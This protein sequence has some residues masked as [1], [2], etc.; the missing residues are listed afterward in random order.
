MVAEGQPDQQP[1][2]REVRSSAALRPDQ[3]PVDDQGHEHQVERIDLGHGRRGPDRAHGAHR[4]GRRDRQDRADTQPQRDQAE[5]DQADGHV[6]RRQEVGPEGN[7][8]DRQQLGQPGHHDVGRVAGGV[9]NAQDVGHGGHLAPVTERHAGH[10]RPEVDQHRHDGD[11][12]R[13]VPARFADPLTDHGQRARPERLRGWYRLAHRAV[14]GRQSRAFGAGGRRP[15]IRRGQ[16]VG[17]VAAPPGEHA[18]RPGIAP[19]QA[20]LFRW[21]GTRRGGIASRATQRLDPGRRRPRKSS[22][23]QLGI[24]GDE[25]AVPLHVPDDPAAG[26]PMGPFITDR[27]QAAA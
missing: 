22:A 21:G 25:P 7:R 23:E 24:A 13:D 11:R 18:R 2:D 26:D 17:S 4:Q 12:Q 14:H 20:E 19:D 10:Q 27:A 15:A 16:A 8:A 3:R 1:A 9:G 5:G 6:D